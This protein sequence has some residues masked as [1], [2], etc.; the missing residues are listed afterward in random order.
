MEEIPNIEK[1]KS[2]SKEKIKYEE[3]PIS[4]EFLQHSLEESSK[5][6]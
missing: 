4:A 3:F 1:Y 5:N 2:R 6:L